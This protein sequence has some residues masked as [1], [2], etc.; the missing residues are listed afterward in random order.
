MN[1]PQKNEKTQREVSRK[2]CFAS[3][4]RHNQQ[5]LLDSQE[6]AR[7]LNPFG[8]S[9]QKRVKY[10]PRCSCLRKKNRAGI[11]YFY[12]FTQNVSPESLALSAY[13]YFYVQFRSNSLLRLLDGC[14]SFYSTLSH[15]S[16][17][18]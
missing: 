12:F 3:N 10:V 16:K 11:F 18:F 14:T 13:L 6:F 7:A 4:V 2:N 9:S 15:T 17:E 8:S 5:L 1:I